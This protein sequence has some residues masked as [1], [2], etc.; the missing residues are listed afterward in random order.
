M[1]AAELARRAGVDRRTLARLDDGDP[2]ASLGLLL[3]ALSILNLARG[4]SEI[5]APE[6]DVEAALDAVR[7]IRRGKRRT[8][9]IGDD[10]VDF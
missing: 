9:T 6:N 5:V 4:F 3:Q 7:Q 1:S 10:E 2:T 8:P